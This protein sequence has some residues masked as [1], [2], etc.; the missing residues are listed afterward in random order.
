MWRPAL[1]ELGKI[2]PGRRV[3]AVDLS[4]HGQSPAWPCYDSEGIAEGVHRAAA[5]SLPVSA[6]GFGG[7]TRL[8]LVICCGSA[9]A[10]R[11]GYGR[12]YFRR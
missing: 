1:A 10:T 4:G 11:R 5:T 12:P 3:L 6:R 9:V 2:D 8:Y 7:N